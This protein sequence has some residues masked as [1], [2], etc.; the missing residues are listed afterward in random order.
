[1]KLNQVLILALSATLV[2]ACKKEDGPEGPQGPQGPEGETGNANVQTQMITVLPADWNDEST[3]VSSYT[4]TRP[5]GIITEEIAQ[6]GAV[7][8]Y[9]QNNDVYTPMPITAIFTADGDTVSTIY[10]F[11][12]S[13][14]EIHLFVQGEDGITPAPGEI[15]Y[16][17][18]AIE[19]S[20]LAANP[21]VNLGDYE[22]VKQ[23]YDLTE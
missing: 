11:Q 14:N 22:E 9:V 6:S 10:G 2:L 3:N 19:S 17:V 12:H 5:C 7:M 13:I 18:V 1:M 21:G 23:A 20:G 16:K 8:C 4:F 15:T